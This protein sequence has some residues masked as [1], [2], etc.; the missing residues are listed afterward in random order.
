MS[1][2]TFA[3]WAM[4]IIF[5]YGMLCALGAAVWHWPVESIYGC[6]VL[7]VLTVVINIIGSKYRWIR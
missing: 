5:G 3:Q 1:Q 4:A 6:V 7:L 2:S